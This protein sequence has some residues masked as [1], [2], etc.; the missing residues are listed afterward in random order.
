MHSGEHKKQQHFFNQ[1]RLTFRIFY[2][3]ALEFAFATEVCK[4]YL[5]ISAKAP[6]LSQMMIPV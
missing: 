1:D 5:Q 4:A 6:M 2:S 3:L